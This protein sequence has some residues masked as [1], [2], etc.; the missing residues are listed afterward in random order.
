MNKFQ[1]C[2]LCDLLNTSTGISGYN[3][4]NEPVPHSFIEHFVSFTSTLNMS[5]KVTRIKK[6]TTDK[7]QSKLISK[8]RR[9]FKEFSFFCKLQN[10]NLFHFRNLPWY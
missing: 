1:N 6:D 8:S 3:T 4:E 5:L 2:E 9:H 7:T 10:V